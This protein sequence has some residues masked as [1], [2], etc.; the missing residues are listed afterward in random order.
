MG[1]CS[2]FFVFLWQ[3]E[4]GTIKTFFQHER[5]FYMTNSTA[6]DASFI[7]HFEADVHTAYQQQGSKLKNTVRSK[8]NVQGSSTTF[9]VIGAMSATTKTRNSQIT[10][11]NVTH[12]PVEC[13]LTDY[14]AGE[15]VDRP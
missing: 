2:H 13:S 8:N 6:I 9:Q 12:A 1:N 11:S 5:K 15:W 14:Y 7:K 4:S 3:R 10:A